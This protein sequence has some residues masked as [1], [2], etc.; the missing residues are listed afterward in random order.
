MN[1]IAR[2]VA[3]TAT[4]LFC[5]WYLFCELSWGEG[6]WITSPGQ[7]RCS[8][9]GNRDRLLICSENTADYRF[10]LVKLTFSPHCFDEIVS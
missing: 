4:P 1:E 8:D 2:G 7:L 3:E 5:A 6:L 9:G 10:G